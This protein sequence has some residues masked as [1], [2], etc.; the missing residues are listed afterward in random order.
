MGFGADNWSALSAVVGVIAVICFQVAEW[1]R[2]RFAKGIDTV[3]QLDSRWDSVEFR[4]IRRE[5]A[6]Y[7]I[8]GN[9]T[10]EAAG[11]EAVR[12]VLNFYETL[13]FLN[14]KNVI[15]SEA[16][17][18]F[19][20]S[21]IFP[22]YHASKPVRDK[23]RQLDPNCY[24]ELESLVTAV[25]EVEKKC[26]PSKSSLHLELEENITKF[27]QREAKLELAAVPSTTPQ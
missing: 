7:L 2:Q 13:G 9:S 15:D 10:T 16:I 22:Y 17:W 5:A 18:H 1:R 11:E 3:A 19:F 24:S 27:L 23:S 21:W 12:T 20:G 4:D 26:H 14:R 25:R 6:A 8:D